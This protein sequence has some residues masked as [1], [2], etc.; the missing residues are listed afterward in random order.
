MAKRAK[1]PV[2]VLVGK[3]GSG[4]PQPDT[5]RVCPLGLQFYSKRPLPEFELIE[6]RVALPDASGR[7]RAVKCTGVV[8][9]CREDAEHSPLYRVWIKFLDLPEEQRNKIQCFA[10]QSNFLCPYC[11]NF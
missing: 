9:H 3:N 8:V 4:V 1:A 2:R 7:R 5:F 6:F 10:K 11:E